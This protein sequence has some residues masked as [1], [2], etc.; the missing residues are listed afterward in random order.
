MLWC[1]AEI[2]RSPVREVPHFDDEEG[3][4]DTL[5]GLQGLRDGPP[6][7][8]HGKGD[9]VLV[10]SLKEGFKGAKGSKSMCL[11]CTGAS[12]PSRSTSRRRR[13]TG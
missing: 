8:G 7:V 6:F 4:G 11:C 5:Q 12:R 13:N 9:G 3:G 10:E 2:L 1:P